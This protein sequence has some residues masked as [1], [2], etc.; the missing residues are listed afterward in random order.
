MVCVLRP[1]TGR[2]AEF[3]RVEDRRVVWA[4]LGPGGLCDVCGTGTTW[5][6]QESG[7]DCVSGVMPLAIV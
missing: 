7:G 5:R 4:E 1:A 3:D 2:V 6:Q